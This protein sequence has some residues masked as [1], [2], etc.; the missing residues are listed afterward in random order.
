MSASGGGTTDIMARVVAGKMGSA[1]GQTTIVDNRP[2]ANGI[3]ASELTVRASPDGYALLHA[4]IGHASRRSPRS[5]RRRCG[6][7]SPPRA[8]R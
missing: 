6:S 8:A 7:G 4:A 2:G 3:I 1:W 5:P